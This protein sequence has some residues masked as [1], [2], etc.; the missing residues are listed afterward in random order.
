MSRVLTRALPLSLQERNYL[1]GVLCEVFP[2]GRQLAVPAPRQR[3]DRHLPGQNPEVRRP[4]RHLVAAL[5][6]SVLCP[7]LSRKCAGEHPNQ[8]HRA[9]LLTRSP[10][11]NTVGDGDMRGLDLSKICRPII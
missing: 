7:S 9:S 11:L 3:N 10:F 5:W 1:K 4:R 8:G 6:V 2:S